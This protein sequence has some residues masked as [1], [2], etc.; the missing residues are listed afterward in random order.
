MLSVDFN[1][2]GTAHSRPS[3]TFYP[4]NA[5]LHLFQKHGK[6]RSI[7]AFP[8]YLNNFK[9]YDNQGNIINLEIV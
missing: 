7:S 8:Y 1:I 5:D 4:S 9:S 2:I 3:A 6:I